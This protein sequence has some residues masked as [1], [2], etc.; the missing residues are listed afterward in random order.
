MRT[1]LAGLRSV[2]TSALPPLGGCGRG[3]P[4]CMPNAVPKDRPTS[5]TSVNSDPALGSPHP[6][7]NVNHVSVL[8]EAQVSLMTDNWDPQK[9]GGVES[10]GFGRG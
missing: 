9:D 5:M 8:K 2:R 1:L 10:L 6:P 4:A 3:E 7:T